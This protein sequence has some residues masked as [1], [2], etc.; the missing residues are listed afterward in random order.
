MVMMQEALK[1]R[2]IYSIFSS[3][4]ND[5]F[6][7]EDLS[8]GIMDFINLFIKDLIKAWILFYI[9]LYIVFCIVLYL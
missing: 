4:Y 8:A 1:R 3:N 6:I 7:S 9:V 5:R 2:K